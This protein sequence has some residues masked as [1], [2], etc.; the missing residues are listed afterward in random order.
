MDGPERLEPAYL[1]PNNFNKASMIDYIL[2]VQWHTENLKMNRNHYASWMVHLGGPRLITEVADDIGAG[3][4]FNPFV[5]VIIDNLEIEKLNSAALLL[6]PSK[7]SEEELY[8]KICSL[9][10]MGDLRQ[11]I[12]IRIVG[13]LAL[14]LPLPLR[15]KMGNKLGEE[16]VF[17]KSGRAIRKMVIKSKEEGADCMRKILRNKQAVAGL[18]TAGA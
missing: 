12:K 9:S 16:K 3:V 10:Y 2:G 6:L 4:H 17:D 15:S 5:K 8:A 18:L 7:F 1:H 13:C 14:S 11:R